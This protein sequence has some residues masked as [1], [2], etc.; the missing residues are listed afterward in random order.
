MPR[1]AARASARRWGSRFDVISSSHHTGT[2]A[3]SLTSDD[4]ATMTETSMTTSTTSKA[5]SESVFGGD[6]L[7]TASTPSNRPRSR[8]PRTSSNQNSNS[9]AGVN[10]AAVNRDSASDVVDDGYEDAIAW[11]DDS[12]NADT[13]WGA[14]PLLSPRHDH[15]IRDNNNRNNPDNSTDSPSARPYAHSRFDNNRSQQQSNFDGNRTSYPSLPPRR[16][17][18]WSHHASVFVASLPPEPN[19]ELDKYIRDTL[20]KHG[21]ILNIKFIH[22]IRSGNSANCAFVQFEVSLPCSSY[23]FHSLCFLPLLVYLL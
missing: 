8:L 10:A 19:A 12:L 14:E 13:S 2:D 6:E 11:A 17:Q 20:G 3:S 22:D 16:A 18:R 4:A 5:R 23:I 1:A 21:T 7:S 15:P 9:D